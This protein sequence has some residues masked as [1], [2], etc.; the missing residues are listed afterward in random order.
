MPTMDITASANGARRLLLV[1]LL[2]V[3]VVAGEVRVEPAITLAPYYTTNVER[4]ADAQESLVTQLEPTITVVGLGRDYRAVVDYG[5]THNFYSDDSDANS[6]H[7]TLAASADYL[8]GQGIYA[9]ATADMTQQSTNPEDGLLVDTGNRGGNVSDT[10]SYRTGLRGNREGYWM[11]GG[12]EVAGRYVASDSGNFENTKGYDAN[13]VLQQG[14]GSGQWFYDL[15]GD[16]SQERSDGLDVYQSEQLEMVGGY[17]LWR[18]I[19]VYARLYQDQARFGEEPRNKLAS[20]GGG[21]RYSPGPQLTVDVGYNVVTSGD[22]DDYMDARLAWRPSARSSLEGNYGHRYFGDSWGLAASHGT[23]KLQQ[24][25]SYSEEISTTSRAL[26]LGFPISRACPP[27]VTDPFDPSCVAASS[28]APS[29]YTKIE[30]EIPIDAIDNSVYLSKLWLYSLVADLRTQQWNLSLYQDERSQAS[31]LFD[32]DQ[33]QDRGARLDWRLRLSERTALESGGMLRSYRRDDEVDR[34]SEWL[35]RLALVRRPNSYSQWSVD[36]QYFE[37]D[38][39]EDS[40][41]YDEWRLGL[42]YTYY[43]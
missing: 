15:R 43:L 27:G 33:Y 18:A 24:S 14:V 2:P 11:R 1:T 26:T 30:G 4:S 5:Y 10:E 23:R 28:E 16:A 6:G 39:V 3:V 36:T 42:S 20:A 25:L 7:N 29:D 32:G 34:D 38:A 22:A 31:D 19:G 9:F 8:L 21:L 13:L 37:R 35:V 12:G 17:S 41:S 40:S